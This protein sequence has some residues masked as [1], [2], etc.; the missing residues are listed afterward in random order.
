MLVVYRMRKQAVESTMADQSKKRRRSARLG[1][2]VGLSEPEAEGTVKL[3]FFE[4]TRDFVTMTSRVHFLRP[5]LAGIG[6]RISYAAFFWTGH[7]PGV[8]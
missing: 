5:F 4:T 8:R 1:A 3:S 2:A 7:V 6:A